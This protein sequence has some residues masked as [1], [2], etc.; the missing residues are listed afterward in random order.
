MA[1]TR[2]EKSFCRICSGICAMEVTIE[3]NKIRG[4]RGDKSDP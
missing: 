1:N 3:D 4:F 2:I